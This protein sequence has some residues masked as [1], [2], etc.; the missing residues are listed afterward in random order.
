MK[1]IPVNTSDLTF[2]VVVIE[3][4]SNREGV[5]SLRRLEDGTMVPQWRIQAVVSGHSGK[6]EMIEVT[7]AGKVEPSFPA[8]TPVQF[9]RLVARPWDMAN[10]NREGTDVEKRQGLS[11]S[12]EMVRAATVKPSTN[13]TKADTTPAPVAA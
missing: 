13:G 1:S 4:K 10:V 6:P 8:G 12:A 11:F 5:Q 3:A 7:V 9:E 2:M